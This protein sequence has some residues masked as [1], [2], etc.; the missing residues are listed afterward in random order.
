MGRLDGKV[1]LMTGGAR[2]LGAEGAQLFA[3][4]GASVMLGDVADEEGAATAE[5][6][7]QAGGVCAYF[8]HDVTKEANWQAI[9]A[10][11]LDQFG[12]LDVLVNNAGIEIVRT[13]QDTTFED[14]QRISAINEHG[15]F[16]G[17]KHAIEPMKAR[18]GGSI[19]NL[20]SVAGMQGFFGLSAYCMS[21][22]GVRLLTKAAAVELGRMETNIRV[23]SIHPTVIGNAMGQRLFDGYVDYQLADSVDDAQAQFVERH[24]IGRLG[25]PQDVANAML[26]LASSES[27]FMTGA[28]IVVDGGL[29]V[30]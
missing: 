3:K 24:P 16:M 27:A 1:V 21:K 19:I 10:Q 22:G 12:G 15:V 4:E 17:I 30:D 7:N 6:I 5:K 18:G 8:H 26:F 20:S 9:V 14:L 23:N 29:C 13:I 2:G 25:A 28:E 11:T